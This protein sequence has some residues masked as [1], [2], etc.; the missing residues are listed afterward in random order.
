MTAPLEL[1][2][3]DDFKLWPGVVVDDDADSS[4]HYVLA[5]V[6]DVVKGEAGAA[7]ASW[8]AP[9]TTPFSARRIIV[10]VAA[11]LWRNPMCASLITTGPFTAQFADAVD[12]ALELS[13][14]QK[15]ALQR[16]TA[17]PKLWTKSFTRDG[18]N[19]QYTAIPVTDYMDPFMYEYPI[20]G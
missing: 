9:D 2:S 5:V 15:L 3:I 19:G 10:Q 7:A 4:A 20:N 14:A 11:S 8:V 6:S 17:R 12:D 13:D 1:V 18:D 16:L